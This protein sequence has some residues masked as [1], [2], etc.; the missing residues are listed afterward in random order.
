[1]KSQVVE[2]GNYAKFTQDSQLKSWLLGTGERELVEAALSDRVWGIGFLGDTDAQIQIALD[3]REHWGENR[4][5]KALVVV[6]E[7]IR[8]EMAAGKGEEATAALTSST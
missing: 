7:R 2:T 5:G 4:L 8:S 3:N 1:M 6:R